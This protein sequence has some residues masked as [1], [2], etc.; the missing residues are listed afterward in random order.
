MNERQILREA[1]YALRCVWTATFRA[2]NSVLAVEFNSTGLADRVSAENQQ[3][4]GTLGVIIKL[5]TVKTLH[6][7]VISNLNLRKAM[8]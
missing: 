4:R 8:R 5:F 6:P 7:L 3:A 1:Y 2:D